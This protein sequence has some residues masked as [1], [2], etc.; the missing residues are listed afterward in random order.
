MPLLVP[1]AQGATEPLALLAPVRA[2]PRPNPGPPRAGARAAPTPLRDLS[3]D[4]PRSARS[5]EANRDTKL[6]RAMIADPNATQA[7]RASATRVAKSNVNRRLTRLQRS[8]L[9]HGSGGRWG[10]T[11]KGKRAASPN[12][13]S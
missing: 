5:E 10:V 3:Q 1:S 6:L 8:G 9:V 7:D 11:E 13:H 12:E 4:R 2:L